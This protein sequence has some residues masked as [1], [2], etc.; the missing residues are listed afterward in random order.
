MIK[1]AL[2]PVILS[3]LLAACGG[4]GSDDVA[5]TGPEGFWFGTAST[6]RDV[7]L[8]V[9]EN[10]ETWG[11]YTHLGYLEGALAGQTTGVGNSFS[12]S[13]LGFDFPSQTL[14]SATYSGTF[15]PQQNLSATLSDGSTLTV[16]YSTLYDQPASLPA[17][18]G[19][20]SGYGLTGHTYAPSISVNIDA[21]GQVTMPPSDGCSG[22]GTVAPRAS[23]K[24]IFNLT[25]TF[26]GATCSL[27]NGATVQG[28]VVY[29]SGI[30]YAMALNAAK[31]DGFIFVGTK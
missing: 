7:M 2:G 29:D 19:T 18:A 4:G 14:G 28:I 31:T 15:Q 9:L 30:G 12:G 23:G 6:G 11:F 16:N 13:G 27:G 17:L 8:A 20:F 24:N 26:S 5:T 10:G 1:K 21:S 25:I 22:S 3:A